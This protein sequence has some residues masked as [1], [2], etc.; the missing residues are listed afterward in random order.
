MVL[1]RSGRRDR[2]HGAMVWSLARD[3]HGRTG[4]P[5]SP[6]GT[7][8][9]TGPLWTDTPHDPGGVGRHRQTGPGP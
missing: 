3:A 5:P 7:S 6:G 2:L 8:H 4:V 1:D 9:R